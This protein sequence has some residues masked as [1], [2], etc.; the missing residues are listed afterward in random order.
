MSNSGTSIDPSFQFEAVTAS[1]TALISSNG[2][3]QRTKA[4]YIGTTGNVAVKNDA[5]T[6][7][8]FVGVPAGA[9]LPVAVQYVMSTNTTASDIVALF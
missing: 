3:P 1:D 2:S 5:G 9:I 6:S 7:V 8:T 4:L